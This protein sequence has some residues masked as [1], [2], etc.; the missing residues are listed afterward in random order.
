MGSLDVDTDE[1]QTASLFVN[2]RCALRLATNQLSYCPVGL[3]FLIAIELRFMDLDIDPEAQQVA[4]QP[5]SAFF[6]PLS[7]IIFFSVNARSANCSR[8]RCRRGGRK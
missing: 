6:C 1:I 8:S 5:A 2:T 4:L 7:Y 3:I